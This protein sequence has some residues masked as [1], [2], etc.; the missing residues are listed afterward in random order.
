MSDITEPRP[1]AR[2]H[3]ETTVGPD[4]TAASLGSGD[5]PVLGTPRVLALAE[6]A[7]VAALE[8]GLEPG[9]TTVG[10]RVELRHTAPTPAG[11]RVRADAVL[12]EADGKRLV[13]EVSVVQLDR[14]PA[15][16]EGPGG[17]AV[18]GG[19]VERVVVDR[20]RFIASAGG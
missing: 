11:A 13:F 15:G 18:A 12:T 5:V 10:T 4:D 20:E 8:G 17:R 3:V 14:N 16:S 1:G 7:T 19:T 6:E 9:R 2:G